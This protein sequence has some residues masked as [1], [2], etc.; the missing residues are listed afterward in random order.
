MNEI[1][2]SRYG[3]LMYSS[4]DTY[5][6]NSLKF[7]GEY[8]KEETD[9]IRHSL[10]EDDQVIEAGANIGALTIPIANKVG[11]NGCVLA[12][13]PQ[14]IA[15]NALCG[16]VFINNLQNVFCYQ[17]ALGKYNDTILVPEVDYNKVYN[18]G[19]ISLS[20]VDRGKPVE[21]I[22]IDSLSLSRC[23]FI[24]ADVEGMELEVL[25]GAKETIRKYKPILYIECDR[26][27]KFLQLVDFIFNLGYRC[28]KHEPPLFDKDNFLNNQVNIFGPIVS[29]N[30]LCLNNKNP[31]DNYKNFNL[32]EI[33]T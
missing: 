12:F 10:K 9:I 31:I 14:R 15:F 21:L 2:N 6:G 18:F 24:K 16:N 33:K 19:S 3:K 30:L 8:S 32:T 17:K 7:Y 29:K 25:Q 28:W 23:N 20:G 1:I 5:V 22:T 11:P 13:E 27:E 26:M 4:N